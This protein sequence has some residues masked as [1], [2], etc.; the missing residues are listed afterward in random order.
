[1]KEAVWAEERQETCT[2]EMAPEAEWRQRLA[3]GDLEVI[4]LLYDHYAASLYRVLTAILGTT[5]DAEDA[6]QEVFVRLAQGRANRIQN[7]RPYL[8][9]AARHEACNILRRKRRERPLEE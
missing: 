2:R 3:Q 7:L 1:M 5:P 8:F 9:A 4:A 6:L